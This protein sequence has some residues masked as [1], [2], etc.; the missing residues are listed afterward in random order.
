MGVPVEVQEVAPGRPNV[1]A[2]LEGRAPGRSLMFCG[3]IDTVGV[4]GHGG[5]V[6]AGGARRPAL[7]PRRP[8][9]E[10]RRGGDGRRGAGGGR[11]RRVGGRPRRRGLR[12]R[13]RALEHRRR[14]AGHAVAGR[15]RRGHRADR[16]R[17]RGG[18]QGLRVGPRSRRSAAPRTAAARPK[19]STPSCHMGRVLGEL[20]ALDR[21]LQ[22]GRRHAAAGHGL[23]PR[24]DYQRRPRA[25]QLSRSLH[26]AGRAAHAARGARRRARRRSRRRSWRGCPPP[27]PTFQAQRHARCSR[28]RRTRS[29]PPIRCPGC[30]ITA[31]RG[32]GCRADTIGMSFWT[33][34]AVLGARRHSV[35]ALRPD[36]RRPSRRRR[37]G[38]PGE[39]PPVPRRACGPGPHLVS[40]P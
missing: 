9:H 33:D 13:R 8:G 19:A 35:G 12:G 28:G 18:A 6:H 29:T 39:R 21:A 5:A 34:A 27:T 31:A 4:A 25:E 22:A 14:R 10:E 20:D 7:R 2:T 30:S 23:A 32:A 16:S 37:V 17:H 24:L 1:V 11:G 15:R 3:H 26:A 38:G 36:R 40:T